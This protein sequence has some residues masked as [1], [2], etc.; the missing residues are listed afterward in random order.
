[1]LELEIK[2]WLKMPSSVIVCE[3]RLSS[4]SQDVDRLIFLAGG[5]KLECLLPSLL[6]L[7]DCDGCFVN[8][9]DFN[10]SSEVTEEKSECI[11]T[12]LH[13]CTSL[14]VPITAEDASFVV[15]LLLLVHVGG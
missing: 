13:T 2:S 10:L 3:V 15:G 12:G 7:R 11:L 14:D 8:V 5:S 9:N 6:P 1:M 4:V